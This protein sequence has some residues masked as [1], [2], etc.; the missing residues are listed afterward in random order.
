MYS[1]KDMYQ[2]FIVANFKVGENRKIHKLITITY[3]NMDEL[4]T[5]MLWVKKSRNG[6]HTV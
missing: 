5:L 6:K 3:S 1:P 4:H 2:I